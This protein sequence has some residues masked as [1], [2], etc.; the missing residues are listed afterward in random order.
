MTEAFSKIEPSSPVPFIDL[1][2]QYKTIKDEVKQA[3]DQVFETQ[4]FV[5]GDEVASLESE[6]ASY[7]ACAKTSHFISEDT[8]RLYRRC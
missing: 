1:V 8:F 4:A 5:L 2:A 6:I 7:C 3:V